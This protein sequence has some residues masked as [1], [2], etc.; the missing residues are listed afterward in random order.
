MFCS[1]CGANIPD[2]TA[3]CPEC[4][5]KCET[6]SGA[7]M[8]KLKCENCNGDLEVDADKG[9][10]ICPYCGDKEKIV[11]SDAVQ[12]EKV[13]SNTY[14]EMEYARMASENERE[15]R[16]EKKEEQEGLQEEQVQQGDCNI[17]IHMSDRNDKLVLSRTYIVGN[18]SAYPDRIVCS[19]M[20]YGNADNKGKEEIHIHGTGYSGICSYRTFWRKP[21]R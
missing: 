9:E 5:N 7:R 13:K 3:F 19:L 21:P 8:I 2:G 6:P 4:G 11:D 18:N 10:Y 12:I 20:A 16:N 17:C 1:K 14:K 15:A